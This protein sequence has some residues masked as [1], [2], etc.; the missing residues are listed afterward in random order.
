MTDQRT[1]NLLLATREVINHWVDNRDDVSEEMDD[2][3][4]KME[5]SLS[6]F[7]D[8]DYG[9]IDLHIT[10]IEPPKTIESMCMQMLGATG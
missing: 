10:D 5:D 1:R 3:L 9:D 2:L 6:V 7:D 8:E 4:S